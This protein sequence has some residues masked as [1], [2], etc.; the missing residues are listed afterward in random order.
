MVR[1][2]GRNDLRRARSVRQIQRGREGLVLGRRGDGHFSGPYLPRHDRPRGGVRV[3]A[4]RIRRRN[5]GQGTPRVLVQRCEVGEGQGGDG[6]RPARRAAGS[7][8][9]RG[10]A[11]DVRMLIITVAM[12]AVTGAVWAK[13]PPAPPADP[14]K[15]AEAKKVADDAAKKDADLLGKAQDRA[16]ANY[17]KNKGIRGPAPK[18]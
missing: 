11:M 2:P 14:T 10:S 15:A 18:K 17:R 1:E 5:L 9:R 6:D 13:L 8:L 16:V 12:A 4:Q 7:A 3:D